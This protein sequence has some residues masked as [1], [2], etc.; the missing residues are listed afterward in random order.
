MNISHLLLLCIIWIVFLIIFNE[1]VLIFS[2]YLS[3][4]KEQINNDLPDNSITAAGESNLL[5]P[6]SDQVYNPHDTNRPANDE[7][8]QETNINNN[9]ESTVLVNTDPSIPI[10]YSMDQLEDTT[11]YYNSPTPS[12]PLNF[13]DSGSGQI[14]TNTEVNNNVMNDFNSIE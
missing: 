2:N 4:T 13:I 10:V 8:H 12:N 1:L 11:A 3:S 9:N 5:I 6:T 14:I 7:S